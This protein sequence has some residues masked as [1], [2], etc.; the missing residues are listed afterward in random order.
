MLGHMVW[1]CCV[2]VS[3]LPHVCIEESMLWLSPAPTTS[4][5]CLFIGKINGRRE[6]G[7]KTSMCKVKGCMA[8]LYSPKQ[9]VRNK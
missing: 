7:R 8:A 3:C 4:S 1:D 2:A 9:G 5:G 6:L